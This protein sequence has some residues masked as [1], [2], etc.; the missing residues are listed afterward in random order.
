MIT[1][2]VQHI[3]LRP[4]DID[5]NDIYTTCDFIDKNKLNEQIIHIIVE[6]M[7]ETCSKYPDIQFISY[8]DFCNKYWNKNEYIIRDFCRKKQINLQEWYYIFKASYFEKDWIE[9]NLEE[10]QDQ[11]YLTYVHKYKNK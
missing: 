3:F 11:I 4:D 9:W 10:Y 6:F 1:Y 5:E 8:I 7:H 2:T